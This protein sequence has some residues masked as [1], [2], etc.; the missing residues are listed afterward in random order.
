M[1][2]HEDVERVLGVPVMQLFPIG[3][4]DINDA[5]R[6]VLD[7]G[8]TVF[9]KT[10]AHPPHGM[11]R[12]EAAGLHWLAEAEAIATPEVLAADDA[13]LALSWIDSGSRRSDFDEQFGRGLALLHRA[14]APSF[15]FSSDNFVGSLPQ[16]NA[17]LAPWSAF[18]RERRLAP[19]VARAL[20]AGLLTSRDAAT[21][22]RLYARLDD[23]V[24]EPEPPARLHGDL[25]GG[26]VHVD[27]SGQPVLIDPAVYGGHREIDLA[28]LQLF[29]GPSG[30]FYAAYD[31]V[32]PRAAGHAERLPLYQLY[33]LLVHVNLFGQGYVSSLMRAV[34]RYV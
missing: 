5:Y 33:P 9:V 11:Y 6:V 21:F 18:Y 23:L 30:S 1:S 32:Y 12:S 14:G 2:V 7:S 27:A 34:A 25:W 28:M 22:D 8:K 10:R 15:G 17:P 29:G 13:L 3:G 19:L 16:P 24:G 4:G 20:S 26:N 31:E